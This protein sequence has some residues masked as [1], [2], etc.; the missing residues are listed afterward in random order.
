MI[1]T[2]K[3]KE[4]QKIFD[5][6]N[7]TKYANIQKVAKRKLDMLHFAHCENDLRVPPSNHL[8]QLK[9]DLKGFYSIRINEQYRIIFKFVDNSAY[10]VQITDYH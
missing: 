5:G 2:F 6:F 4:T 3:C 7:S 9:G 10:D 8:E 1:K